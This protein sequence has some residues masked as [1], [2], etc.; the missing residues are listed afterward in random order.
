MC[1][2]PK[3]LKKKKGN[4][5]VCAMLVTKQ[6]ATVSFGFGRE[7]RDGE[8]CNML[9]LEGGKGSYILLVSQVGGFVG[10]WIWYVFEC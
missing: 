5:F 6:S 8:G 2:L 9:S 10:V 7:I 1:R 4:C 3:L